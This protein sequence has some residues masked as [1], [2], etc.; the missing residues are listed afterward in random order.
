VV[1]KNLRHSSIFLDS[2][3]EVKVGDYSLESRIDEILS[4]QG[5]FECGKQ[6]F[7]LSVF[8][9]SQMIDLRYRCILLLLEEGGGERGDIH[10]LGI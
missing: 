3:G 4:I 8:F 2:F 1:H 6:I 9:F 10:R 7:I 5:N